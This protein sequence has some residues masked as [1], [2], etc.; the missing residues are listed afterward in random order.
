MKIAIDLNDVLRDFS[1]N[2]GKYYHQ[3]YDHTID[4]GEIDVWTNDMKILFPFKT[5]SA[6]E[7]FTYEKYVYELFGKCST[8]HPQTASDFNVWLNYTLANIYEDLD[9]DSIEN[10]EVMIVSPMEYGLSLAATLF[11]VSKLGSPIREFYFPK[12]SLTIWDKCDILITANPRLLENKPEE[13][14][15]I[16]VKIE[17]P[18][19]KDFKSDFSYGTFRE[20]VKNPNNTKKLFLK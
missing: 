3:Y 6:Y 13:K 9:T 7:Q 20:F 1:R 8:C 19:N 2:F 17:M 11:F 15:K 16:S 18:Y 4:L 10:I 5:D 14:G 12:D